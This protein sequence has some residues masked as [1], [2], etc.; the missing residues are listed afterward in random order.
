MPLT[1]YNSSRFRV[2]AIDRASRWFGF[3]LLTG[4][5]VAAPAGPVSPRDALRSIA[6]PARGGYLTPSGAIA[7]VGYN[8]M[9]EM[10]TALTERFAA[11]H[12]GFKFALELK[13]TRTGP[14]ALAAGKSALAPMG[15]E[16]S[17]SELADYRA[18][19]GGD[20][21]VVRLAH[22]SLNPRALSG[23]LAIFVHQQNPLNSLTL[24]EVA[25]I[26]AGLDPARGLRPIGLGPETA[27][28]LFFRQ[29]VLG[30]REFAAD[31]SSQ[32][33]SAVV[34]E[35]VGKDERAIGFAAAMRATPTVKIL[36]LAS[37]PGKPPV[38]LTAENL[39]DGHYPLNR[40]LLICARLPLEPWVREFLNFAL[41]APGQQLVGSGTLGYLP[42]NASDVAAE[43]DK[44]Q[45]AP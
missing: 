35:K 21:L 23:P 34:V 5:L 9:A 36:A 2:A 7:I 39:A 40:H 15:A 45:A 6:P 31:F 13:G 28:G 26:F 14:P 22:A 32:L 4:T 27:L 33:Q 29:R 30:P 41:S 12:P 3:L 19:T 16:F 24:D 17:P 25:A 18:A 43:Q 38:T 1:S 20:P 11:E 10:L 37:R 44:I 8:D 42:L